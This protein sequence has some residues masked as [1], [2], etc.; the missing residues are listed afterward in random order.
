LDGT[1]EQILAL[2]DKSSLKMQYRILHELASGAFGT[3]YKARLPATGQLVAVKVLERRE[4]HDK[5]EWDLST[6][7]ALEGEGNILPAST[8]YA[9][10]LSSSSPFPPHSLTS[11]RSISSAASTPRAGTAP[12]QRSS[13]N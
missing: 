5:E 12:E 1:T 2:D 3:V 10:P 7:L 8:M 11:S 13:W 9:I 6:G 4:H